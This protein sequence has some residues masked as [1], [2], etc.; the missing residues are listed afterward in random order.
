MLT[1]KDIAREA[2]VSVMTVSRVINNVPSK[3]SEETR[4]RILSIIKER[5]YV[6][7][8]SARSLSSRSSRIIA[9][10]IYGEGNV[11]SYPYNADMLGYVNQYVQKRGYSALLY[12]GC[13][14]HN[15]TRQLRSWDV[16]GAIVW[17]LYDSEFDRMRLDNKIPLVFTDSYSPMRQ[18][19]NVGIDDRKGGELAA[20][21]LFGK[22]HREIAFIGRSND[23]PVLRERL[24]GFR[25][26]LEKEGARLPEDRMLPDNPGE[27]SF[28]SF[29]ASNKNVTAL[30]CT[31]D[32]VALK[33]IV[34]LKALG[35]RV[36][37]D[38]SVMGFDDLEMGALT[39]PALTTIT[40]DI[41]L[42]AKLASEL[43]FS[44]IDNPDTPAQNITLDVRLIERESV[45]A[46]AHPKSR[47]KVVTL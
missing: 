11:L 46:L 45:R 24:H 19:T 42:K 4:W 15:M 30:F 33:V 38:I 43:L 39:T 10:V 14:F 25:D 44:H 23:S 6:P 17:G 18:L 41:E 27:D 7:N 29:I 2:G 20:K 35:L 36:P 1:M 3:V 28:R 8:S 16:D 5:G 9:V 31:S 34:Y 26:A 32:I 47:G 40:Q 13:D 37:D 12:T 22:G 21:H